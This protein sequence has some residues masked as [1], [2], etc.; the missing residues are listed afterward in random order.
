MKLA[1]I[2]SDRSSLKTLPLLQKYYSNI[3]FYLVNPKTYGVDLEAEKLPILVDGLNISVDSSLRTPQQERIFK[4]NSVNYKN[5][6]NQIYPP[7]VPTESEIYEEPKQGWQ[8]FDVNEINF[9]KYNRELG[10]YAIENTKLEITEYDLLLVQNSQMIMAE[11]L[12]KQQN[13]FNSFTEQS[14]SIL[15]LVFN[16]ERRHKQAATAANFIFVENSLLESVQ[17]NW[18]LVKLNAD[19]AEVS[20]YIPYEMQGSED[21]KNFLAHRVSTALNSRLVAFNIGE[22]IGNYVTPADGYYTYKAK[23]RHSKGGALTPTYNLWSA[24]KIT[25]HLSQTLKNKIAG[26][27]ESVKA[28]GTP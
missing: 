20:F 14:K 11:I 15:T 19:T 18:Y 16:L 1:Y 4:K 22:F 8:E 25:S 13:L 5:F 23:L 10:K 6:F 2:T 3:H 9:I 17:D 28:G 21:Y 24:E 12:E 7:K 26:K 27:K